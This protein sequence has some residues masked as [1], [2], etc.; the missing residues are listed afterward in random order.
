MRRFRF[1]V[2]AALLP[3]AAAPAQAPAALAAS[4]FTVREA[5]VPMRDGIRLRTV[6][7]TPRNAAGPLPILFTRTPYGVR[8][9]APSRIPRGW[10][11]LAKDG[12]IFVQQSMRGRFGSEGVFTLST[13]IRPGGTDESTDA[14]DSIDWLVRNTPGAS[15]KVGMVGVSYPGLAAGMALVDPHPALKA[16]SPQAAWVDYWRNDDLH[17]NGAL[18]LSYATD[19]LYTLQR[20]PNAN[21]EFPYDVPDT[22]DWFLRVGPVADIDRLHFRGSV[23]M[24]TSLLAHPNHDGF[25]LGQDWSRALGRTTVPTLNVA[26]YWDQEDP[27]GSWAIY[28]RQQRDDPDRLSVMVAGPWSHGYWT[29]PEARNLGRIDYGVPSGLQFLEEVQAPFFAYWLHGRGERPDYE[30]RSFQSGTWAWRNHASWPPAGAT[31]T[32]LYLR[33]DGTLGFDQ[34][35]TGCRSYVSDPADPVPY[36]PRPIE[37]TYGPGSRWQWWEAEDQRFLQGRRDV[38]SWVGEP[39]KADLTVTGEVLAALQASTSGTDADFV[40]KLIDVHPD[41]AKGADG[42]DLGGFQLPVAMEVRRGRFLKNGARPEPLAPNR[43]TA[44]DVPM[45]DHDHVFRRGHRLMVQVQSSWF[46]A[47]DRNP[48]KFV[49]DIARAAPG[50]FVKA[51]QRVCAGSKVMLPVVGAGRRSATSDRLGQARPARL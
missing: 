50:D 36:R 35:G 5:M 38:L 30:V 1:L 23:P 34:P 37:P 13:A 24:F 15:G 26:G 42:A 9:E 4:P 40:V 32:A 8:A 31:P 44:W 45:R 21:A 27:W 11:A 17:R 3:S 39:L 46:P 16:V 41:G 51:T 48:Q 33:P 2:A 29:R 7:L 14:Y 28:R 49:P 43:V 19:W 25:Y 18:R 6:I 10:A 47:I 12:Y 20:D 22:Y